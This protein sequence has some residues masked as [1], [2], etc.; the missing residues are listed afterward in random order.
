MIN[1]ELGAISLEIPFEIVHSLDQAAASALEKLS[2]WPPD[3]ARAAQRELLE[4]Q[5]GR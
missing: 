1:N 3:T 5:S 2:V 4:S